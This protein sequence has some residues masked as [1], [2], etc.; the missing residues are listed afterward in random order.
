MSSGSTH[1]S[2]E[3]GATAH[4]DWRWMKQAGNRLGEFLEI[5]VTDQTC[6]GE[7]DAQGQSITP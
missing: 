2:S 5:P 7:K 3:S 1:A 4:A 6:Q